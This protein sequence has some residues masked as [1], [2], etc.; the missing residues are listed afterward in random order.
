MI[1]GRIAVV[2]PRKPSRDVRQTG[3]ELANELG[4]PIVERGT[5]TVAAVM[6][7]GYVGAIAVGPRTLSKK[8]S[9][10]SLSQL[11]IAWQ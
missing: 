3:R 11:T 10:S 1:Q 6:R 2:L 8:H 7:E 9:K 5:R 4:C